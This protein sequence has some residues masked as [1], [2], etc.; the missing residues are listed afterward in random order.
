MAL[1]GNTE[2]EQSKIKFIESN[3]V[4][5]G[6]RENGYWFAHGDTWVSRKTLP[7]CIDV[8]MGNNL[9]IKQAMV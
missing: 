2:M 9:H 5:F 4:R 7:E 3:C 1:T 8:L 6:V